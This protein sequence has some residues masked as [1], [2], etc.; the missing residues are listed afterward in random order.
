MP[1]VRRH[2]TQGDF[3]QIHF[4]TAGEPSGIPALICLHMVAKSSRSFHQIMPL[5]AKERLVVAVDYPGY[6]ESCAPPSPSLATIKNY[7]QAML[8]VM[9]AIDIKSADV[10]GY[11]T[12]SIVAVELATQAP[13]TIRKVINI[14]APIFTPTEVADFHEQYATLP[15]NEEGTRFRTMWERIIFHRGQGMTLE[16]CAQSLAETLRGGEKYEWG[17]FAAFDASATYQQ[18]LPMLT[19]AIMVMNL[20][21]DLQKYTLRVD[22]LMNKNV[23]VDYP[24]WG[25]GFL[26]A[27]PDAVAKEILSFLNKH[28]DE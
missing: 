26:D 18:Q 28:E 21:D 24:Q 5:L 9:Q 3:G 2:F 14:S 6:G 15:L 8:Q 25:A 1:V 10:F 19:Q 12:G 16:M 7:A 23:R 4:R 22:N 20:H 13:T 27:H 11:H 17:H